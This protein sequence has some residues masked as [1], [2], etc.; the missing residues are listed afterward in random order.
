MT[1]VKKHRVLF[2]LKLR[3]MNRLM[4]SFLVAGTALGGS[5]FKNVESHTTVKSG[6]ALPAG[7]FVQSGNNSYTYKST[8][9]AEL[10]SCDNQNPIACKY[11]VPASNSIPTTGPYTREQL[12]DE[13]NLSPKD[14]TT[15]LW[16]LE[17]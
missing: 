10:G 6:N 4:L 17:E 3:I 13:F 5:A 7:Y 16:S 2:N 14:S 1:W 9:T 15:G 12:R 11:T 8:A